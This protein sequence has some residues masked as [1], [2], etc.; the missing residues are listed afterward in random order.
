MKVAII[1]FALLYMSGAERVLEALCELFPNATIFTHAYNPNKISKIINEHPIKTTF[2]QKLPFSK[3]LYQYYLPLMPYA[4]EEL[5][6]SEYDLII[7]CES[8]P[9]KGI[10]PNPDAVHICYCHSPMRYVWDMSHDYLKNKNRVMKFFINRM[11]H[12]LKIWDHSTSSRV[13]LFIANSNFVSNRIMKYYR[14]D[15]IVL[16]PPVN[17]EKFKPSKII[18]D[19]YLWLGRFVPYKRPD[20][21]VDAFNHSGKKLIMVGGSGE[22]TNYIRKKAKDNI[23]IKGYQSYETIQKLLS[24]CKALIFPGIEDAGIVP[25]EAMSAGRPVIA[26]NKGGVQSTIIHKETGILFNEQ[27]TKSLISAIEHFE[28]IENSFDSEK[29]SDHAKQFDKLN[30][31]NKLEKIINSQLEL[32]T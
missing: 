29:I 14:R 18:G 25:V 21:A 8:G 17:T 32:N 27:T 24:E 6:L 19:Y 3:K 31:I 2:I 11:I 22:E 16:P 7:S 10:V 5:D 12:K 1:H 28:K 15:S 9:T 20:I 4:L 23:I 13:D 30:F 26:F